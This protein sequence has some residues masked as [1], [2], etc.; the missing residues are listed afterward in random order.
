MKVILKIVV[1]FILAIVVAIL[2]SNG[3]GHVILFIGNYRLDLSFTT[4]LLAVLIL[5]ALL[6]YILA[7][8]DGIYNIPANFILYRQKIAR[9]KSSG[10]FNLAAT[11]YFLGKYKSA[12][13]N[14][15]KSIS[16]NISINDKFP[17]LLLAIDAIH[18]MDDDKKELSRVDRLLSKLSGNEAQ[19]Y[20]Y[21]QLGIINKT[22]NNRL[23]SEILTKLTTENHNLSAKAAYTQTN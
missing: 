4:L 20:I 10:Y 8:F 3:P 11:N 16:Q 9:N 15:L 23:Y 21:A 2:T 12:Y 13:T 1:L 6:S 19:S 7:A 22:R 5:Y 14:A 17:V 18:Q